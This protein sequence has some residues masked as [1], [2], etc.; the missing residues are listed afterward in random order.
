MGIDKAGWPFVVAA[1]APALAAWAAGWMW[2]AAAFVVLAAFMAFFFRDPHRTV[3]AD[4]GAIVSPADGRV[5][6]AGP[7]ELNA[8]PPGDW[9]Q[10]S[11]FLSPLD[12]HINRVP[13]G[14]HVRK[15]VYT[16]GAFLAAYRPDAAVKNERNEVWI[17]RDGK[18]VVC[19][20]VVGVVA[21]R[22]V[23]RVREG[24]DVQTG[25]KYGLMKFGSRIDL[26][27]P[28]SA[29][30]LVRVG[31]TVRGGETILARWA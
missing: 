9:Q 2:V 5:M 20:Q 19:R 22:L 27:L 1:L 6:I 15:V 13:I 11:I 7:V 4:P 24:A 25:E 3:P 8:A 16:R 14:G 10:I 23:C 21:R 18:A 29:S 17:D 26:F 12:V 31:Q 28:Q 30:L